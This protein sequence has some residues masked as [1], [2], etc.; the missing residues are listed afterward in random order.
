MCGAWYPVRRKVPAIP[1]DLDGELGHRKGCLV[2]DIYTKEQKR[3][4]DYRVVIFW[5][6]ESLKEAVREEDP[7]KIYISVRADAPPKS[8]K[9]LFASID[10]RFEVW[11][12]SVL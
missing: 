9:I 6:G 3:L 4:D 8:K 12:N 7:E 1:L 5:P 11:Y 10:I 2:R